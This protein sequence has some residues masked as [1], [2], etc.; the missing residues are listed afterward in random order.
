MPLVNYSLLTDY[1]KK[2]VSFQLYIID[3]YQIT[4][5]IFDFP[6]A[7]LSQKG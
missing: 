3:N 4:N 1:F 7:T 6:K 5:L 2:A